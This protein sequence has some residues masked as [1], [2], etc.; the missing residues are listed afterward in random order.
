MSKSLWFVRTSGFAVVMMVAVLAGQSASADVVASED[1]KY[2]ASGWSQN[3][4]GYTHTSSRF[5]GRFSG[6]GGAQ[7]ISKQFALPG[8]QSAVNIAFDFIEVDSWDNES[9]NVYVDDQLVIS[10]VFMHHRFDI[11]D[12]AVPVA[13]NGFTNF[14]FAY[15]TDQIVRYSITIPTTAAGLKLGFGATLDERLANESWGIDNLI[16]T[17]SGE[18]QVGPTLFVP[19]PAA[20]WAGLTLLLHKS[21][22]VGIKSRIDAG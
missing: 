7:A 11:P 21:R 15:W 22:P 14:G 4:T 17:T 2:G 12:S 1:F 6:S 5:L 10:D 8:D 3:I 18:D 13:G 19:T 16:I 20:L 9:F